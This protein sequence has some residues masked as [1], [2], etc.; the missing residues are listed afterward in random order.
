MSRS[1]NTDE[2]FETDADKGEAGHEAPE[3]GAPN[4]PWSGL[5]RGWQI[6][7]RPDQEGW[8]WPPVHE[9]QARRE[10]DWARLHQPLP[11]PRRTRRLSLLIAVLLIGGGIVF[12]QALSA[13][14]WRS[15]APTTAS[16]PSGIIAS[17]VDPALVDIDLVLGDQSAQAAATG[18]VLSPSGLV[19]TNNHVVDG[20]TGIRAADL[21]NGRTYKATVL[22]YDASRDVALI[23]LQGASGL[24]SAALGDSATLAIGQAV[25]G[26]GNAGGRGGTPSAAAGSIVALDQQI[27][28]GDDL[29]GSSEQLSG[30]IETNADIQP[31]DSG[32]PLVDS[33][34]QVIAMDT[35]AGSSFS[36]G[37][38]TQHNEGF[39]IPIAAALTLARQIER[40][41][42]SSTVH[43]GPTAFLGVEFASADQG[44][45]GFGGLA[46]S[47][48]TTAGVVPGTP[49]ARS[50]LQA[51]DTIVSVDGRSIDSPEGLTTILGSFKPG[52]KVTIG[53]LDTSGRQH[54]STV[55]LTSGPAH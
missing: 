2:P 51:G 10:P 25:T 23:K 20:A 47:G 27:T 7:P 50:G 12:G 43:I 31:G 33:A 37:A 5:P 26:V 8:S 32:G 30:L 28:A 55:T 48:A 49:A 38:P 39:A 41:Q 24:R 46:G 16:R 29:D 3:T 44:S 13:D 11:P 21:G 40:G 53:W 4:T 17:R 15:H 14:F 1:P 22:G 34:G 45:L 6:P 9:D 35:A 42:A 18:I 54:S 36:F 19:L 52:Q